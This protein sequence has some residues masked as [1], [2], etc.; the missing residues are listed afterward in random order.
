MKLRYKA[1]CLLLLIVMHGCSSSSNPGEVVD[2]DPGEVVDPTIW[3]DGT[4][5]TFSDLPVILLVESTQYFGGGL[6]VTIIANHDGGNA[7]KTDKTSFIPSS[8][9]CGSLQMDTSN[10]IFEEFNLEIGQYEEIVVENFSLDIYEP[11]SIGFESLNP[12]QYSQGD[13]SVQNSDNFEPGVFTAGIVGN[14]FCLRP[15]VTGN[16]EISLYSTA[17]FLEKGTISLLSIID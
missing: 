11:D 8:N 3:V 2:V 10:V 1:L 6:E 14:K 5:V 15:P 9:F 17:L 12:F 13:S 16:Q 7:T 4:T